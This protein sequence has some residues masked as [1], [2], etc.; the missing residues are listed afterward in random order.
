MKIAFGALLAVL[1]LGSS[2]PAQDGGRMP[3]KGRNDDPKAAMADAKRAS[4]PMMIFFSS[5]GSAPC[6]KLSAGAF[7]DPEVVRAA[8][9]LA[10]IF[11]ECNGGKANRDLV[12]LYGIGS[13]PTVVF[14]DPDGRPVGQMSSA[15][16]AEAAKQIRDVAT[17]LNKAGP[18]AEPAPP[19]KSVKGLTIA[20]AVAEGRRTGRPV[21]VVFYDESPASL[22][23]AAALTDDYLK[24]TLARFVLAVAPYRKGAED[25]NRFDVSRAPT[26]LVLNPELAKMEEKPLAKIE[27][28]RSARELKRDLD[29]ALLVGSG[30]GGGAS[31]RSRSDGVPEPAEKLS[32]D[33][34]ERKFIKARIA[35]ALELYKRGNK[36]KAIETLEDVLKSYPKHLETVTAK[37][38]LEEFRK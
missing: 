28:S 12:D 4:Q 19:Q 18:A 17:R 15:V 14:C 8:E 36:D 5:L 27:G 38:L 26:I 16:P 31:K 2:A 13:Y 32:D 10:C 33:E 21:L 6:T 37:K 3:W 30:E 9:G 23:V 34:I 20:G 7:S 22:S 25:A 11:V 29:S 24:D 35:A 1:W